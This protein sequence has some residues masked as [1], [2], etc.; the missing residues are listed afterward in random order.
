MAKDAYQ[1]QTQSWFNLNL[2]SWLQ[3]FVF[4]YGPALLFLLSQWSLQ[5][6]MLTEEYLGTILQVTTGQN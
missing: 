3:G 5:L 2:T 1:T 6:E 4:L